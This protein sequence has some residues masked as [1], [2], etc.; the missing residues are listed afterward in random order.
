MATTPEAPATIPTA[1]LEPGPPPPCLEEEMK[2][3]MSMF[4]EFM[5]MLSDKD[6]WGGPVPPGHGHGTGGSAG[7]ST[8]GAGPGPPRPPAGRVT[9]PKSLPRPPRAPAWRA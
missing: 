6:L 5:S 1:A 3:L 8:T 9:P 2:A 4:V 7:G